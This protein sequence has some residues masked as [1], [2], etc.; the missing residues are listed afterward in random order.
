[1]QFLLRGFKFSLAAKGHQ[2]LGNFFGRHDSSEGSRFVVVTP[3]PLGR[4]Q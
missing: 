3:V 2:S 4:S 1:V